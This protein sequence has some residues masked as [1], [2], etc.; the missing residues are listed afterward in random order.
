MFLWEFADEVVFIYDTDFVDIGFTERNSSWFSVVSGRYLYSS[1][2]YCLSP[3]LPVQQLLVYGFRRLTQSAT[4]VKGQSSTN[5]SSLGKLKIK[6]WHL[7][8]FSG[9][10]KSNIQ[11]W[12]CLKA[13]SKR[14]KIELL[15]SQTNRTCTII[16]KSE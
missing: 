7:K 4:S 9:I 3:G 10:C 5:L 1:S 14:V 13:K 12:V 8:I 15:C 11:Y 16:F 2:T 6:S